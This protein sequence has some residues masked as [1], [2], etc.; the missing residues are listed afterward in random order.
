[1]RLAP[2]PEERPIMVGRLKQTMVSPEKFPLPVVCF[3]V[4]RSCLQRKE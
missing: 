4:T 3:P 2:S 1:M